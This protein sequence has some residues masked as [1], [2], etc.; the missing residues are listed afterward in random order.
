MPP[1]KHVEIILTPVDASESSRLPH[2]VIVRTLVVPSQLLSG[3][4][5]PPRRG[6]ELWA[7]AEIDGIEEHLLCCARTHAP[8]ESTTAS[9]AAARDVRR[10]AQRD[11]SGAEARLAA[12]E[13]PAQ[14]E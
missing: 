10:L 4:T 1:G 7:A 11:S 8:A 5:A 14:V 12:C 3:E 2:R 6:A 9:S 13:R